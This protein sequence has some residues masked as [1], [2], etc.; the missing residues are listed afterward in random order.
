[1]KRRDFFL[2][3]CSVCVGKE[4]KMTRPS[5]EKK[6][7]LSF[8]QKNKKQHSKNTFAFSFFMYECFFK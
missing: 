4:Q 5:K 3:A 8:L 6:N 2:V 7:D 1:M